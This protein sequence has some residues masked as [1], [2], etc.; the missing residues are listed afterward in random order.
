MPALKKLE[1][2]RN[3]I[4]VLTVQHTEQVNE[5]GATSA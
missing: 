2:N 5:M 3:S 4:P 1:L